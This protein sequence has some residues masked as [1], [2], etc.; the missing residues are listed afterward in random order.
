MSG[1]T[2]AIELVDSV[3][4]R[5]SRSVPTGAR[6]RLETLAAQ[7]RQ[8]LFV[9][10]AGRVKAGKSTLV[11]AMLGQRVARTDAR[12][13]TRVVTWFRYGP[14]ERVTVVLRDGHRRVLR[15]D[16]DG[17]I[18]EDLGAPTEHV[19]SVEVE[20]SLQRLRAFTLADTPGLNAPDA[21][22]ATVTGDALGL[23]PGS[24]DAIA[25][26]EAVIFV[27]NQTVRETDVD[28][29]RAFHAVSKASRA[30]VL[31]AFGVLNKADLFT[32]TDPMAVGARIAS[33]FEHELDDELAAVVAYSGLFAEAALCGV[34]TEDDAAAV[35][36]IAVLPASQR[37]VMLS[38]STMFARGTPSVSPVSARRLFGLLRE[39]GLRL[40][41][42]AAARGQTG[43]PALR[44]EL[45]ARSGHAAVEAH[46]GELF[47]LNAVALKASVGLERLDRI[48]WDVGGEWG[49]LVRDSVEAARLDPALHAVAELE[50]LRDLRRG[51]VV[52]PPALRDEVE[53][54]VATPTSARDASAEDL[55]R[56]RELVNG[57]V[58]PKVSHLARV[59]VRSYELALTRMGRR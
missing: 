6:P 44:R 35:A 50:A 43:A 4:E 38:S 47:E 9:A 32:G 10:V 8:P 26:A 46:V 12:E 20:L 7:L 5:L 57:E 31:S 40:V 58:S 49:D 30:D 28:V 41:L 11:N 21:S 13:C 42:D 24:Q 23:D 2:S 56:W 51:R 27:L 25:T 29:L 15:L 48:A 19:A 17:L 52:L 59:V 34:F 16:A 33:R 18:P 55:R 39:A 36:A 53:T 1:D 54:L 45:L 14:T 37:E 22:A 3:C